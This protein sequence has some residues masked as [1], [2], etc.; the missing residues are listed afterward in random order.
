M[1]SIDEK[2]TR[3]GKSRSIVLQCTPVFL[4]KFV[5]EI[6]AFFLESHVCPIAIKE[7]NNTD[8]RGPVYVHVL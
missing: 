7:K 3:D 1:G 5:S 2:K 8:Q 4:A 6:E